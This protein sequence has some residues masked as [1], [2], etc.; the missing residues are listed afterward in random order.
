[1]AGQTY[2]FGAGSWDFWVLKLDALGNVTWQKTYGGTNTDVAESAQQTLDGGFVVAGR[3]GS[4][5]AG[6]SDFWV[7]KLDA[8]GN[9][10]WQKTYGGADS[11]SAYSIQ[12][13]LD[14]GYIL[15]G[16]TFS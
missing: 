7:L 10:S 11:D 1:V 6:G 5:S 15:A 9:V 13:T 4:F 14:G 8:L 12:Q 2:S 3:T 16:H